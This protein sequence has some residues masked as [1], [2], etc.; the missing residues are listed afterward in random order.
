MGNYEVKALTWIHRPSHE[1]GD[2]LTLRA[3]GIYELRMQGQRESTSV[4]SGHWE[5]TDG[6]IPEVE[7]DHA[8]YPI[9]C[10]GQTV[11]LVIDDDI[12]ARYQKI[13]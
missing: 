8:G 12:D 11:K 3:D 2:R 9:K 7:L 10:D 6:R 13:K 1:I 4:K 5:F